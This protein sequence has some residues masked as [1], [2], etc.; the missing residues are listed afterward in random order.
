[1]AISNIET[2]ARSAGTPMTLGQYFQKLQAAPKSRDFRQARTPWTISCES[3][4]RSGDAI[5]LW[6]NPVAVQWS[7]PRRGTSVKTAGGTIR[8]IWR[9]QHRRTYYDE[10]EIIITF[11]AG[12]IMPVTGYL[13]SGF[14]FNNVKSVED[15]L[16]VGAIPPG[17][18]N[19]Y[20]F[21]ALMDEPATLGASENHHVIV[22][23]SRIFPKM[24]LK[25][26]FKDDVPIAWGDRADDTGNTVEW[27]ATFVI[28][29]SF[30]RF[31]SYSQ[32]RDTYM[33]WISAEGATE[34]LPMGG[35]TPAD[36]SAYTAQKALSEADPVGPP[37]GQGQL[38]TGGGKTTT[39]P[40]PGEPTGTGT[41]PP[42]AGVDDAVKAAG[43]PYGMTAE[44]T[45]RGSSV[46]GKLG[47]SVWLDVGN[48]SNP[49]GPAGPT[50]SMPRQRG[51]I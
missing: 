13:G 22:Y 10:G 49:T 8:S 29:E 16:A 9:N 28:Y 39:Q 26:F 25:G 23:R 41:Y 42:P 40:Y 34:A 7:L 44:G 48:S 3:W 51:P 30:P 36:F 14:D 12:N 50:G 32:L 2:N 43:V 11:Q 1:M 45:P 15:A 33:S 20:Q 35:V 18:D 47:S 37:P 31:G 21:L 24:L 38:Q 46:P 27:T 19:F 17:L 4:L 5:N 6:T